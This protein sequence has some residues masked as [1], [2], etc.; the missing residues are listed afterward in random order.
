[1]NKI[2]KW[3]IIGLGNAAIN[4]AKAFS[5]TTNSQ[6]IA[7]ASKTEYKRNFFCQEFQ[8]ERKNIYDNYEDILNNSDIDILYISLPHTLHK[9]WCIKAA[10]KKKNILVEKPAA[11]SLV[12]IKEILSYVR[13]NDVF[14]SEGL[15]YRFHPFFKEILTILKNTKLQDVISIKGSFGNDALGGK[16]FFGLRFKKSKKSKRLFN[17]E[18]AGGAIW[19][20]GCYP[21]SMITEIISSL[22]QEDLIKPK[23][24]EIFRNIGSTGV[25]EYSSIKLKFNQILVTIET[26]IIASLQNSI[27][28]QL[29]DG[30]IV[31]HNPWFPSSDTYIEIISNSKKKIIKCE[32]EINSYKNEIESI[33]NFLINNS[34]NELEHPLLSHQNILENIEIL[35]LWSKN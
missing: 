33:S 1:M 29:T 22:N 3:G 35:E 6:L 16:K 30:K 7:V 23:I 27:E 12:D 8:I 26:S 11:L 19:D 2:V 5:E 17:P 13:S 15:A 25:D 21:L 9:E 32:N 31:L 24:L 10:T 4:L 34:N 28:I 18:L 20:N 14:F